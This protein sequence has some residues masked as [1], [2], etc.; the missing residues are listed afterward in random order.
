VGY[1]SHDSPPGIPADL[2]SRGVRVARQMIATLS[3]K[4]I[5]LLSNSGLSGRNRSE[6]IQLS[7]GETLRCDKTHRHEF[8]SRRGSADIPSRCRSF[9]SASRANE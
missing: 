7:L 1:Q 5:G 2:G 3:L 6:M 4:I 8:T 9:L